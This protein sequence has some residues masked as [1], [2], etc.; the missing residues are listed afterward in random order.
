MIN[1]GIIGAGRSGWELH[2]GPLQSIDGY[3]VTAICDSAPAR[4]A[5]VARAFQVKTYAEPASLIND[6]DVQV[7]VVAVPNHQHAVYTIA[8]LEAGKHVICE[9]PM[10]TTLAEADAMLAAAGRCGRLLLVFHNRH[11]DSDY[12]MVKQTVRQGLL[13]ELMTVESRIMTYGPEWLTFGV[14]E[15]RPSWRVEAAYGGGFLNDWGAHVLEQ[16]LDLTEEWPASVTCHLRRGVW[17]TE[18]DDY[19]DMKLCMP[20]GL[21]VTVIGTNDARLPLPRWFVV[22]REGTLLADGAWGNW[23]DIRIRATIGGTITDLTPQ[24]AGPTSAARSMEVSDAL[25]AH[26]YADLREV[27]ATGRRAEVPVTR[28]RDAIAIMDAARRSAAIGQ[29]VA[30][31]QPRGDYREFRPRA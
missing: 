19:F 27:L 15:F 3:R 20:S 11:W 30:P 14:P 17:A 18:T 1:I 22:G 10:A 9:K 31:A 25:S 23:G 21:L 7:V 8:A 24:A 29:A 4:L 6:P 26:F 12:Q 16:L 28:A 2:A 13:G 5:L